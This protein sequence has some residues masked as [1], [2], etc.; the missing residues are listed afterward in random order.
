MA[1]VFT[2]AQSLQ[3]ITSDA[4][5][6][7]NELLG[8]DD[9]RLPTDPA[10]KGGGVLV[11]GEEVTGGTSGATG[12]VVRIGADTV[13]VDVRANQYFREGHI[14]GAHQI[15]FYNINDHLGAALPPIETALQVVVYCGSDDCD[16]A[17]LLCRELRSAYAIPRE[18]LLLYEKG[19]RE[20]RA[21]NLPVERDGD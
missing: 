3:E 15:D 17:L 19:M 13:F 18:K 2:P 16:D 5:A 4:N 9:V 11:N 1:A 12:D 21:R 20:W 14:P 7:N 8:K 10:T 6:P